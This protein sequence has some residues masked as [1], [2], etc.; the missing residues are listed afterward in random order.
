MNFMQ[1]EHRNTP[2]LIS[3][4]I[5]YGTDFAFSHKTDLEAGYASFASFIRSQTFIKLTMI[6]GWGL[7]TGFLRYLRLGEISST[8]VGLSFV[9]T[10][11]LVPLL[12]D[13]SLSSIKWQMGW[14]SSVV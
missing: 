13:L 1:F 12:S 5:S 11:G 14:V 10:T 6:H 7:A 2:K 9:E 3:L 8:L 4:V